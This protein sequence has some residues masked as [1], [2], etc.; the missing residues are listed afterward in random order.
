MSS[1]ID[2]ALA[3]LSNPTI[4][5]YLDHMRNTET[6]PIFHVWCLLSAVSACLTRRCYFNLGAVRIMPN[7]YVWLVG[8]PGVRKSTGV[9]FVRGLLKDIPGFR[10]GP[11]NTA[12]RLQGLLANMIGKQSR[13]DE[14][15]DDL[16]QQVMDEAGAKFDLGV[17]SDEEEAALGSQHALN[18]SAIYVAESELVSFLG[19]KSNEF[20]DFLG[21]LW[22]KS[23]ADEYSYQLKRES[24]KVTFPCLNMLGAITPM[25]ITSYLAP[26]A[27][28]QGF[29]SRLLLV[30]SDTRRKVAW[31]E[32]LDEKITNEFRKL[33]RHIY[34]NFEGEFTRTAGVRPLVEK[35]YNYE[36]QIDDIRFLHYAQRRQSHMIKIAMAL[37]AMRLS[38]EINEQDIQDAHDLLVLT[39]EQMPECL[40]EHGLS[41]LALATS[42]IT[43]ILKNAREPLTLHRLL[44]AT[45]SDVRRNEA[46]RAL[47]E[48]GNASKIVEVNLRDQNGILKT[49]YVW[50]RDDNPFKNH[51][52]I[53]VDYV[54]DEGPGGGGGRGKSIASDNATKTSLDALDAPATNPRKQ[55][56]VNFNDLP[57]DAVSDLAETATLAAQGFTS[58]SD[59]LQAF[60]ETRNT[61]KV[62]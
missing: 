17:L 20:T 13:S 3:E 29:T 43:E 47:H 25:H 53:K 46:L 31:P 19:M 44:M 59:K 32:P 58:L 52:E 61:G 6:P 7:Q 45:G 11:N 60:I 42:R 9:S 26:T 35:L 12:G 5:M 28:G 8:A 34:E 48:M 38:M 37:A 18:R 22:D 50:P 39:E 49:G 36:V 24:L 41:P 54:H 57:E 51:E 56:P 10:F 4:E 16:I 27:I 40:G 1:R 21:D 2:E 15:E 33:M 14:A 62:H 23:G 55:R 30:Y